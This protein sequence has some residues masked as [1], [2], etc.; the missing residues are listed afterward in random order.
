VFRAA[1]FNKIMDPH[2]VIMYAVP[3]GKFVGRTKLRVRLSSDF[4]RK[5]LPPDF[6]DCLDQLWNE[7]K[8]LNPKLWNGTKF[9]I[10]SV[11]HEGNNPVFNLG[12]SDYKDFICTNW[13][14][15][16][17]LYHELGEKH[18][19]NTQAYMSDALGVGSLVETSDGFM[20]LL[21]RS[22]HVGEAVG[23][24][25]IPGGHPEPEVYF[26]ATHNL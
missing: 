18:H 9:R 15:N 23:L 26:M 6:E 4:N 16:A 2:V 22:A 20:I 8:A 1:E 5:P 10:E 3:R 17:K 12:L 14:P 11:E 7:K 25:D 19:N 13:S 24:W 21:K